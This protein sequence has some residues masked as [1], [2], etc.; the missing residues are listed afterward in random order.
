MAAS[1]ATVSGSSNPVDPSSALVRHRDAVLR[2]WL[3]MEVER[4]SVGDLAQRPL[5]E[6]LR[7]LEELFDAAVQELAAAA[8][9]TATDLS[10]ALERELERQRSVG[11]PFTVTVLAAPDDDRE[12]W[13][14]ALRR[15]AED[16]ASVLD[17]DNGLTAVILPGIRAR[18]GDVTVDR[19]RAQAW[20]STGC[21]GRLP[22]AGRASCPE[23]GHTADS[24]LSVA[25]ERL[26]RMSEATL[27]RSRFEREGQ[28]APVTTLYP[29]LS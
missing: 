17:A 8:P 12:R 20:S 16:G 3:G 25:H 23:D 22:A 28:P 5:S 14:D 27:D 4:S 26:Q 19:L 9:E 29:E 6:R 21:Q 24:L 13:L 1:M 15:S 7:E 11:M 10:D 2:R 18:E